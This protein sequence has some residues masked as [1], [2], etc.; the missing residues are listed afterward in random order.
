MQHAFIA[1]DRETGDEVVVVW[2]DDL[3]IEKYADWA[4]A[5]DRLNYRK[6]DLRKEGREI[7]HIPS[8]APEAKKGMKI[9]KITM[10]GIK[11]VFVE[12]EENEK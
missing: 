4:K 11:K 9:K 2:K 1:R 12:E 8:D 3:I 6:I 7:I 10:M 5:A